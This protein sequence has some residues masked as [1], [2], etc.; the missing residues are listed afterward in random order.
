MRG[1]VIIVDGG[2]EPVCKGGEQLLAAAG[3]RIETYRSAEE[4]GQKGAVNVDRLP[5]CILF[6][7]HVTDI[8]GLD[9]LQTLPEY[10]PPV[11]FV[12]AHA[13]VQ[14]AVTALKRGAFDFLKKPVP[15]S[16][17]LQVVES[18]V[19]ADVE[20]L[21]DLRLVSGIKARYVASTERERQVLSQVLTGRLNK[22]IACE[23]NITEKTVKVHRAR[24]F[25]KMAAGSVAEL[26]RM[27]MAADI[28]PGEPL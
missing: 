22:V 28:Q 16:E 27:C 6:N 5:T 25:E 26:V 9:V 7:L 20:R 13:D 11:V 10:S 17:V 14:T 8:C 19:D 15:D 1:N 3:Y 2:G 24:V 23:L 21:S 18:A 12:A 4:L